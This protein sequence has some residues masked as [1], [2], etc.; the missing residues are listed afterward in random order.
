MTDTRGCHYSFDNLACT[1]EHFTDVLA[2]TR[3]ALYVF[4]YVAPAGFRL[5]VARPERVAAIVFQ[6]GNASASPCSPSNSSLRP[7][8]VPDQV[9]VRI[10][11]SGLNPLDTKIRAAKAEHAHKPLPAVLA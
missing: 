1:I 11:A 2:L 5:A 4:D 3:Y 8:L 7:P 9:L 6:Y 10:C